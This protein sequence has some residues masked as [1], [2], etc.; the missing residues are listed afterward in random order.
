[1]DSNESQHASTPHATTQTKAP[2]EE[3]AL[4]LQMTEI[5]VLSM[6]GLLRT[7]RNLSIGLTVLL[8]AFIT[9]LGGLIYV[10]SK[11]PHDRLLSLR[12]DGTITPLPL[13]NE[14][15]YDQ[16]KVR[17]FARDAV[18]QAYSLRFNKYQDDVKRN[19]GTW[20]Q[21]SL[22]SFYDGLKSAG[23]IEKIVKERSNMSATVEDTSVYATNVSSHTKSGYGCGEEVCTWKLEVKYAVVLEAGDTGMKTRQPLVMYVKVQRTSFATSDTGLQITG[24]AIKQG[25]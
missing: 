12:A 11:P 15:Y 4:H 7:N 17:R 16:D 13:L 3:V 20:S 25:Q 10:A 21:P 18:E 9:T 6:S 5:L 23:L 19:L 1:M 24:F 14:P 22:Q 2:A 8:V